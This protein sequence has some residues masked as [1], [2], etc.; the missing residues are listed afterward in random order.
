MFL[1]SVG[2]FPIDQEE[3][4]L[5]GI[6]IRHMERLFLLTILTLSYQDHI[7]AHLNLCCKRK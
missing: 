3:A 1:E 2:M 4:S 7:W 5:V 6:L